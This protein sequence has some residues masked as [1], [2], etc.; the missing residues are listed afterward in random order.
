M[1]GAADCMVLGKIDTQRK[2]TLRKKPEIQNF[3]CLDVKEL[4]PSKLCQ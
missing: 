3:L 2:E 1:S 4:A